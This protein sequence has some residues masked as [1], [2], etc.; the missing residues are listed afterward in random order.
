MSRAA[1]ASLMSCSMFT[2]F[3]PFVHDQG[4]LLYFILPNVHK[5]FTFS[6][7]NVI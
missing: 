5:K 2:Q 4:P 1:F 6:F 3:L 7:I